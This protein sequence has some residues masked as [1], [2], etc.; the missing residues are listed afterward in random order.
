MRN[1]TLRLANDE[2]IMWTEVCYFPSREG[3]LLI[4]AAHTVCVE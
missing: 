2:T 1:G 4:Y 3:F